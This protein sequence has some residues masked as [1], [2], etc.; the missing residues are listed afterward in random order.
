[1]PSFA[2]ML[3]DQLQNSPRERSAPARELKR[4]KFSEVSE[5]FNNISAPEPAADHGSDGGR[6]VSSLHSEP[7]E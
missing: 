6:Q 7:T 1:M 4:M 2:L 5:D 3:T